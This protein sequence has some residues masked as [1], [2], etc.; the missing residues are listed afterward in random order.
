MNDVALIVKI[1]GLERPSLRD[2]ID[3]EKIDMLAIECSGPLAIAIALAV[4]REDVI[5]Q[6]ELKSINP[7]ARGGRG[8]PLRICLPGAFEKTE[9]LPLVRIL[10]SFRMILDEKN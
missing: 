6:F 1:N 7:A 2:L 8:A 10:C 4:P 3:V 9:G 5:V